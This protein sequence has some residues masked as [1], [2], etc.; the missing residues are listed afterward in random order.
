MQLDGNMMRNGE[1][2]VPKQDAREVSHEEK[3]YMKF[4][5]V[6]LSEVVAMEGDYLSG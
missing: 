6:G 4:V 1:Q 3:I 5:L 2:M